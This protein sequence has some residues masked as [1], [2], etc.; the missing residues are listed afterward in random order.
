MILSED[1]Y[2]KILI[3]DHE[4]FRGYE[5]ALFRTKVAKYGIDY[6][7]SNIEGDSVN[8]NSL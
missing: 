3:S 2:G 4:G 5:H 8:I 7:L 6:V 1:K